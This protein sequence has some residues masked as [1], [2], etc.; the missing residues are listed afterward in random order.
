MM[1]NTHEINELRK[2]GIELWHRAEAWKHAL[3]HIERINQDPLIARYIKRALSQ[4]T[5]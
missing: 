3:L 1:E 4:D 2:T 5:N